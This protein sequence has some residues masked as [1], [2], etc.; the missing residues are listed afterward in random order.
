[1][2]LL[3]LD[4]VTKHFGDFVANEDVDL[5][6]DAGEVVG[7]IGANGAGKTTAIRQ[8]LGLLRPTSGTVEH[9]GRPPSR[10][11]RRRIGY[12]PQNLGLWPDLTVAENLRFAAAAYGSEVG[13]L[14]GELGE[15]SDRPAGS[16]SLGL[17]RRAAFAAALQHSPDLLV[18]DEPTSGVDALARSRLWDRILD[19]AESGV[20]VLVTTHAMDEAGQCDRL[21]VLHRGKVVAR[22]SEPDIVADTDVIE[23]EARPWDRVF[24]ALDSAGLS[25]ALKGTTVRVLTAD[26][27]RVKQVLSSAGI[28]TG[29][30]RV[31]ATLEETMVAIEKAR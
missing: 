6:V 24:E 26:E 12:V 21:V 16:L 1:M 2:S 25:V 13:N 19:R 28:E 18:L 17:Q 8:G 3:Q 10:D 11:T 15:A 27:H 7:L 14:D 20:G 31:E 30:R 5:R 4:G 9:F 29:T 23:V 22:G